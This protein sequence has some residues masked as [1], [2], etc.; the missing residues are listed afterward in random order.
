[1]SPKGRPAHEKALL[2]ILKKTLGISGRGQ[3]ERQPLVEDNGGVIR[4]DYL[5][6]EGDRTILIDVRNRATARDVAMASAA[7]DIARRRG[8]GKGGVEYVI[9]S[10]QIPN[11][12]GE[13]ARTL[14]VPVLRI[15]WSV[16]LPRDREGAQTAALRLSSEK[17][18]RIASS[19]LG[20]GPISVRGLAKRA[21]VSYGW[22][23]RV[24]G[25]LIDLH[26]AS[27]TAQ[28]IAID[29]VGALLKGVAWERNLE[30]LRGAEF[31][32]GGDD[33]M[34]AA[35]DVQA[36][37]DRNGVRSA[38]TA[39][40]AAGIY[41]NHAQ[42]FDKVY[43]YIDLENRHGPSH[44]SIPGGGKLY[45][46]GDNLVKWNTEVV[47]DMVE[48]KGGKLRLAVYLP[49]RDVFE[50]TNDLLGLRLVGPAQALLDL[51][52]FG[53]GA[54]ELTKELVSYIEKA[55]D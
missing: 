10:K 1:M 49:D 14:E 27:R 37:L 9:L 29:D 5:Y 26:I 17:A 39:F 35:R 46:S 6:R 31:P 20:S 51:A 52:G 38:L 30:K 2:D 33:V 21:D 7:R 48:V 42:R 44:Q 50:R 41:T 12:V 4:P 16:P 28:G 47:R 45:A 34:K 19:L 23:H 8:L 25:R 55:V 32:V 11:E 40:T 15:E 24:V 3:L 53:F 18:W 13:L 43:I 22:A 36:E 54:W